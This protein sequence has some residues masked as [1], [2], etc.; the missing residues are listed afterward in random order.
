MPLLFSLGQHPALVAV[1]Q[2]LREGEYLF[3]CLDDIHVVTEPDRVR[4]V[5]GLL[6]NALWA[7]AGISIHQGKT[8]IWN[9]AGVE[10]PGCH[11]LERVARIEDPS[12]HVWRG[13]ELPAELQGLNILGHPVG[14]P[15]VRA[16]P[17][18]TH[19]PETSEVVG[20]D[21]DGSRCPVVVVAFVALCICEGQLHD[22]GC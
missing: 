6:E 17:L 10:P 14:E 18:G 15:R 21:S 11:I 19:Y 13:P 8:K 5:V 12:A 20:A 16:G 22:T 2:Q 3:A 7:W 9:R 4:I 1:Q